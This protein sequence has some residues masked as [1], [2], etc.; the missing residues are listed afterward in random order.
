[1]LHRVVVWVFLGDF[2]RLLLLL[3]F[4]PLWACGQR[5]FSVVHMS[6]ATW[7]CQLAGSVGLRVLRRQRR[8]FG[9]TLHLI[10]S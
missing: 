7:G 9:T 3:S 6:T 2:D 8:E 4:L 1:M 10:E 5:F